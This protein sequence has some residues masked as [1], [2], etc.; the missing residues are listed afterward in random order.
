MK[1]KNYLF[2]LDYVGTSQG[3][4]GITLDLATNQTLLAPEAGP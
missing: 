1:V 4:G 2:A 3:S